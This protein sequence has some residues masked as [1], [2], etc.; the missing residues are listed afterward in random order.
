VLVG[1]PRTKSRKVLRYTFNLYLYFLPST[2][3]G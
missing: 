1:F 3:L 2:L